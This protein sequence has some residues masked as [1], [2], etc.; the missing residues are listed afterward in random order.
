VTDAVNDASTLARA[1]L[2]KSRV[3]LWVHGARP[4]SLVISVA[5]ILLGVGYAWGVFGKVAVLP[6][7]SALISALAI[8]I[9][10][11]LANDAAD[12][13]SGA[14][15]PDR[16]GPPRLTGSGILSAREVQLGAAVATLFASIFGLFAV[17]AGGLPILFIGIASIIAGWG[18]SFGPRPISASAWGEIFV[19]FFF[20]VLAVIGT[21]WLAAGQFSFDVVLLGAGI[22]LPAGAVLTVNNHRD[23][24][25]DAVAG[26]NTLAMRIGPTRTVALY[27]AQMVLASLLVAAGMA[28]HTRLGAALVAATALAGLVMTRRVAMTPISY[29]Q[30]ERLA[31]TAKFQMLLALFAA[32]LLAVRL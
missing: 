23:R 9:A 19:V 21:V 8:Q 10:T 14:D 25:Q 13:L 27:G 6:V 2:P 16:P 29:A 17:L 32:L 1:R 5:P 11:N 30:S 12:G 15:H 7:L 3:G 18:Y 20:G 26:R 4:Y 28:P 22:G 31:E 24:V